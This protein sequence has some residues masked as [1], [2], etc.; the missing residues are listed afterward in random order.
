MNI[1]IIATS[2][3][4]NSNSLRFSK[5]LQKVL[6]AEGFESTTVV[7][8]HHFDIPSVGRGV[9]NKDELTPFQSELIGAWA[10]ADLVFFVSPEYNWTVNGDLLN[11]LHQLGSK[12]FVHLFDN[13]VFAL[14]GVSNGRG[15]KIPCLELTT[16]I[17]KIINF[18]HQ[19]SVVSPRIYESHETSSNLDEHSEST[20]NKIYE[21][22]VKSFV[23]YA[24]AVAQRWV[25]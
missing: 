13:K 3:R 11:A 19:Y 1:A 14:A 18:T 10:K 12:D 6:S 21:F 20:G 7:D 16:V 25:K 4:K 23:E 17:N 5:Y 9:I 8:F 22:T 15:G 24:V 2:P